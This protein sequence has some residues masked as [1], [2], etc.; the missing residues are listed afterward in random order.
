[1][2][3]LLP[4]PLL[5]IAFLGIRRLDSRQRGRQLRAQGKKVHEADWGGPPLTASTFTAGS[6][7]KSASPLS[8]WSASSPQRHPVAPYLLACPRDALKKI[9]TG[10]YQ[11]Q[12]CLRTRFMMAQY[13]LYEAPPTTDHPGNFHGVPDS[14]YLAAERTFLAWVRT[15]LALLGFGIVVARSFNDSLIGRGRVAAFGVA[16]A[17]ILPSIFFMCYATCVPAA[18]CVLWGRSTCHPQC[19]S[20]LPPRPV[21]L[22]CANACCPPYSLPAAWS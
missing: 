4:P 22:I 15:A 17:A 19:T 7:A 3:V 5:A 14:S 10:F 2:R 8:S 16:A 21:D 18:P 11:G 13:D 9:T 6:A 12:A 1:M 20:C